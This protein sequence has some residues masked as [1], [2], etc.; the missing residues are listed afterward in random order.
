[1]ND[2]AKIAALG[3]KLAEALSDF[4][5]SR[6]DEDKKRIAYLQTTLCAAVKAENEGDQK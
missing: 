3:R 2:D 4:A 1:V 6:K 5:Y